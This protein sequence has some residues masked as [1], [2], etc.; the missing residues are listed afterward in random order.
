M[1]HTDIVVIGAGPAGLIAAR[2]AAEGGAEVT[3]LEEHREIGVPCHCAGL[4]SIKGLKDIAITLNADFVQNKLR[5]ARFHSPSGLSFTVEREEYVACVVDRT[6][7]DK[8]LAQQAVHAGA[9]IKLQSRVQNAERHDEG[10]GVSGPWGSNNASVVI[11]AEGVDSRLVEKMGLTPL[12]PKC[13]LPALQFEVADVDL[14][15]AYAEIHVGRKVAP[16]FFAWVIPLSGNSA[17]VGLACRGVNPREKLEIFV[18]KRFD[19]CSR[20]SVS[21]GCV[22]S[23][24]PIPRTYADNFLVVGD[25]AGQSKSTTGGGVILGGICASFAGSV[26]AEAVKNRIYTSAFLRK[27]ET[28]WKKRLG[29]E[30]RIMRLARNILNRLSDETID[31]IFKIVIEKNLQAEFSM[32]GDMDFQSNLLSALGK[33]KD[34]LRILL[35]AVP[36]IIHFRKLEIGKG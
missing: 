22:I 6:E 36:D 10:I 13:I 14:D 33:K 27:Y 5:G 8:F 2:E 31:K 9:E 24:G 15:P 20:I 12:K 30:F 11:D 3:V 4:L 17:R 21:S 32:K 26:A 35:A 16:G 25:A 28:L 7:F 29:K 1:M 23:C 18:K 19:K 34:L